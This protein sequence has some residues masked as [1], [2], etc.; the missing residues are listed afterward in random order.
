M[1]K[2]NCKRCGKCCSYVI[3]LTLLD[4]D[5]IANF[6]KIPAQAVFVQAVN[7][8]NTLESGLFQ[9]TKKEDGT[10]IYLD[11]EKV[12]TIH[13]S[14]PLVCSFFDCCKVS[15]KNIMPWTTEYE[16][17]KQF[18]QIWEQA[19]A[20]QVTKAYLGKNGN[21]FFN[22]EYNKAVEGIKNNISDGKNKL[23]VARVPEGGDVIGMVYDCTNC[24]H[25]G[26][27][28]KETLVTLDDIARISKSIKISPTD[29][30]K[31]YLANQISSA[32][33]FKMI[34][35]EE[36]CC[37]FLGEDNVC[38]IKQ[39]RPMHCRFVPCPSRITDEKSYECFYLGS[40][41]LEEQFRHQISLEFTR[42]Y[43]QE[44]GVRHSSKV[45]KIALKNIEINAKNTAQFNEFC[46]KINPYRFISN[47]N[48]ERE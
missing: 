7:H 14:K 25:R 13:K 6:F 45:Y 34:K 15:A 47:C 27:K 30:H 16:T 24:E 8:E 38:D 12:C 10:C 41:T 2:S 39:V 21:H 5:R 4:I 26:Q 3:P 33:V 17:P 46:K 36:H 29:F 40:G 35:G 9:L 31:K 11:D 48:T 1:T 32:D 42:H 18:A 22:D 20:T 44:I 19:V 23:K 43:I 28:A 37:I